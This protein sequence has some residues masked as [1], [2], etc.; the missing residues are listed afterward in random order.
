VERIIE[1]D[2]YVRERVGGEWL[3]REWDPFIGGTI[4]ASV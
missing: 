2:P 3:L 1:A 4:E